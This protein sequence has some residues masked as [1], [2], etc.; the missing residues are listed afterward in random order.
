MIRECELVGLQ[1]PLHSVV[2][3]QRLIV[4]ALTPPALNDHLMAQ[5][6]CSAWTNK[7]FFF[8]SDPLMSWGRVERLEE[9]CYAVSFSIF[10]QTWLCSSVCDMNK[11]RTVKPPDAFC[12]SLFGNWI[13][14]QHIGNNWSNKHAA[15]SL[16]CCRSP[17]TGDM[18]SARI[19]LQLNVGHD[20]ADYGAQRKTKEWNSWK[21]LSAFCSEY[22]EKW[23]QKTKNQ[24]ISSYE[25][26]DVHLLGC[27]NTTVPNSYLQYMNLAFFLNQ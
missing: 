21:V 6:H 17:L 26:L 23:K 2:W 10:L 13:T 8:W 5:V 18:R 12:P 19:L 16:K 7:I 1:R 25:T 14:R 9:N 11:K 24:Q 27:I 3:E 20:L 4:R 15:I 22:H